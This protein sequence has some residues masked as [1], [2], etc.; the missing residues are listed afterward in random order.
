MADSDQRYLNALA[1]LGTVRMFPKNV[2]LVH[3]G[4]KSDQ[5]Y[6]VQSGRVKVFLADSDGKEITVDMLGPGQYFGEMALEG[7]PRSA[8]VMTM[9]PSRLSVI[10]RVQFRQFFATNP[11]AAYWLYLALVRRARNLTRNVGSLALLDVYGR[12][13]R[14]LLDNATEESGRLVVG[15]RITQ[16]E[17]GKRV[18]A[19]RET[20]SRILTDL[21]EGNYIAIENNRIVIQQ[22]LPKHW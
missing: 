5:L 10:E 2:I 13:A 12:V 9:E 4:D 3:E 18:G 6:V 16:Q 21:R 15:E 22:H 7:E 8:S 20:V 1:S 19:S 11:D 17:I 14:L